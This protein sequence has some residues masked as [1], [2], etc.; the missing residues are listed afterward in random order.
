M[1]FAYIT[2]AATAALFLGG[3]D[4]TDGP[5]E[6]AAE[7]VEESVDGNDT[8]VEDVGEAVDE[9]GDNIEEAVDNAADEIDEATTP[10]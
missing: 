7:D 9:A 10:E 2:A 3:C 1:K 8:L 5:I 6:R 4:A